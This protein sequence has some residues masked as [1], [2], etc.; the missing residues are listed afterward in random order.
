MR[1]WFS[2]RFRIHFRVVKAVLVSWAKV[3]TRL[4]GNSA[5]MTN[6]AAKT[7]E[8]DLLKKLQQTDPRVLLIPA[9][10][11]QRVVRFDRRLST[12]DWSVPHADCYFIS[13]ERLIDFTTR[14]EYQLQLDRDLPE[15]LILLP[16]PEEDELEVSSAGKLLHGY[17][18][19]LFHSRVHLEYRELTNQHKLDADRLLERLCGLGPI[20][21]AE[22]RNVL[23]SEEML[24]PPTGYAS[25]YTE[26]AATFLELWYFAR[27]EL[28]DFFPATRDYSQIARMLTDDFDHEALCKATRPEGVPDAADASLDDL[29]AQPEGLLSATSVAGSSETSNP[30][31]YRRC[32][33]R[34]IRLDAVGNYAKAAV[35]RQRA[36]RIA[37]VA[38]LSEAEKSARES[39]VR[40]AERLV[41]VLELPNEQVSELADA[42]QPLVAHADRGFRSI[43]SR[44]LYD[45]QKVCA[46]Q[47][48]GVYAV[49]LLRWVATIGKSA[50][51][52]PLPLLR[53]VL[54]T[55]H[56]K[57]ALYKLQ[58]AHLR[59]DDS[60][61]LSRILGESGARARHLLREQV[62]PLLQ[63]V[64]ESEG[65]QPRNI[66]EVTA[67]KKVVE[68]LLD[69][70]VDHGHLSMGHL[71]DSI[72]QS[73]LKL[74]DL[75]KIRELLTGD[76]LLRID[77]RL[78]TALDG[79]Y[80]RGPI[81]LRMSHR[82]SSVAFGTPFGRV[83]TRYVALPF[84]GAY[85][86][87]ETYLH[88]VHF[89]FPHSSTAAASE[90]QHVSS[91]QAVAPQTIY[92]E[93][94]GVTAISF[95]LL[96]G[97]FLM[98]LIE[99]TAFRGWCIRGLMRFG[100]LVTYIVRDVPDLLFRLPWVRRIFES[101]SYLAFLNYVFKPLLIS[102]GI[103][104]FAVRIL[105]W[106]PD[107]KILSPE[108][109]EIVPRL[110]PSI[111]FQVWWIILFLA[112]NLFLNS[113]IGRY[114]DALVM[115]NMRRGWRELRMKV[116]AAAFRFVVD[117]FQWMLKTIEQVIY[118]VDELLRFRAGENWLTLVAKAVL[119]VFW[120]VISYVVR[121]YITLLIEPQINPIKHFPVV[122]VSHKM[123]LPF[124]LGLTDFLATPLE[125]IGFGGFLANSIAGPTVFL[126]P[127]VFGF[128][129]WELK[130]NWRLYAANQGRSLGNI[131][132]GS[133]GETM[134]RLLRPGFHSGTIPKLFAKLRRAW[135]K[136]ESTG[137][138]KSIRKIHERLHHVEH[139][140]KIFFER[141][142]IA[143][144][145][146]LPQW[147]QVPLQVN[148]IR[149][150][151]NEVVVD[152]TCDDRS[153]SPLRL[154]IADLGGW[155]VARVTSLGWAEQLPASQK[156][157]LFA[158]FQG[159]FR[160]CGVDLVWHDLIKGLG[161]SGEPAWYDFNR[162]G[163][164]I[165]TNRRFDSSVQ[166]KLRDMGA[167]MTLSPHPKFV[168][169][170]R[171]ED[172]SEIV[173]S[174]SPITWESWVQ[175]WETFDKTNRVNAE[176]G[177]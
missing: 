44:L 36:V 35:L 85:L 3:A 100:K 23:H 170:P 147:R 173:F 10:V 1:R 122:T 172:L 98:L 79:V 74:P 134:V 12:L 92:Q 115:D 26:F 20:P 155:L 125:R 102:S 53:S 69:R 90:V 140:V 167:T 34:S 110:F 166:Y 153:P 65:C 28:S 38:E 111:P 47:D 2:A 45:L 169:E 108:Q 129:A 106:L 56:L 80:H 91:N 81:Y 43:E 120:S 97:I 163:P 114:T 51:R 27:Q 119:G 93:S 55:R 87:L 176:S 52:R 54:V 94:Q 109:L 117:S 136:A 19:L 162:D 13:R 72:S 16:L 159:T 126:L 83:L 112:A 154:A 88:L 107:R 40:F 105:Q 89:L 152:I 139:S 58:F 29:T 96:V 131:P 148:A 132:V 156:E 37:S 135:Y 165:W 14:Y 82:I 149:L 4:S 63:N 73:N 60:Q 143:L 11:L 15:T 21:F 171:Q 161:L 77:R 177:D 48:R 75:I 50:L 25:A 86:I 146:E 18:R 9:R 121:I 84:G 151:T 175:S 128:L 116:F 42:L 67:F 137:S 99:N 32:V 123:I 31:S 59:A 118:T 39:I 150:A 158:A 49:D 95:V 66:V 57:S 64:F 41:K 101:T 168:T 70:V 141:E 103:L 127:G 8:H 7:T 61:R 174:H 138:H 30:N 71:R 78:A 144:L 17:W 22:A 160:Y 46:E 130:E 76:Q 68:E 113:P 104:L 164:L 33:A 124:S 24:L 145:Q 157:T 5:S 6:Q 133:H 142:W 62:R